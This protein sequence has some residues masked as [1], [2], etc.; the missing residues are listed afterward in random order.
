MNKFV[1][2]IKKYV[3]TK[4]KWIQLYSALLH[5]AHLKGFISGSFYKG[6]LKNVCTP[7]LNCYSCPGAAAACPLGSL[8]NSLAKS[9]KSMLFYVLGTLMLYGIIFGRFI[10]GWLCPFGFIQ[11][12]LYK[13]KTPKLKKSRV[14]RVLS[15]LKYVLL[16]FLVILVPIFLT[17]PGFCKLIC[18]AGT[19]E[20][21]IGLVA[22]P[23][24]KTM[25]GDLGFFFTWKFVL[26]VGFILGSIF[27][28]RFFCRFFC[29]LGAIYGFFNRFAVFGIR[30]E[31]SKCVDC[32]RC[33]E[34]CKM[35]I[36]HVGDHEC[37]NCGECVDACPTGAISWRGSQII[38]PPSEIEALN[39]SSANVAINSARSEEYPGMA[40]QCSTES[41]QSS[42]SVGTVRQTTETKA[43]R[44]GK[45]A[46]KRRRADVI[47]AVIGGVLIVSLIVSLVYY[48]FIYKDPST[49]LTATVGVEVGNDLIDDSLTLVDGST[50]SP[51]TAYGRIGIIYLWDGSFDEDESGNSPLDHIGDLSDLACDDSYKNKVNVTVVYYGTD[52]ALLEDADASFDGIRFAFDDGG[53]YRDRLG[54]SDGLVTLVVNNEGIV[55]RR[56][57]TAI[58]ADRLRVIVDFDSIP[59]GKNVGNRAQS[60]NIEIFDENGFTG[61]SID[62]SVDNGKIRVVN[63]W[64]TWC[65]GC[66]EELPYFDSVASDYADSVTVIAIHSRSQFDINDAS[67]YVDTHFRDSEIIFGVDTW[68]DES[69]TKLG[70][71]YFSWMGGDV[72]LNAYPH[73]VI[74]DSNGIILQI[75]PNA[76]T[77]DQLREYVDNALAGR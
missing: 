49:D 63:F 7:G 68:V 43:A 22:N 77:E 69:N 46:T 32:G 72:G 52:R 21:G 48:N 45:N 26:L 4:R 19:L 65:A 23:A 71:Y 6:Q 64:G 50:F 51:G 42:E 9:D 36:K 38:L 37:I 74:L 14:T 55:T 18:P 66:K 24:N 76:V 47:R 54:G 15:Y 17:A 10:C 39:D 53:A 2:K 70:E 59:I 27:I 67:G 13:I 34:K 60:S 5:N 40:A 3:P 29:P 58:S 44:L 33:H 62:P 41:A 8:Q 25:L 28:F 73:T 35:D 16:V 61:N 1:A 11:E 57:S 20:G 12:L 75:I 56:S 31:R 30:L